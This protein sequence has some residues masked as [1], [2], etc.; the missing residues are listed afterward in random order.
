MC[1]WHLMSEEQL[2][3]SLEVAN[4]SPVVFLYLTPRL[5]VSTG[6]FHNF[7][8]CSAPSAPV[9]RLRCDH[10][11]H[12]SSIGSFWRQSFGRR[13]FWQRELVRQ[14][15]CVWKK[16]SE[17]ASGGRGGG[18]WRYGRG[19]RSAAATREGESSSCAVVAWPEPWGAAPDRGVECLD[20]HHLTR[21][22]GVH[23]W[24][25]F[26]DRRYGF[27]QEHGSSSFCLA[28]PPP[29]VYTL[30]GVALI[31][32]LSL[33]LFLLLL[34]CCLTSLFP[35]NFLAGNPLEKLSSTE[36]LG[37]AD[38]RYSRLPRG[39]SAIGSERFNLA[40]M[41]FNPRFQRN[42]LRVPL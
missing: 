24:R 14:D 41:S 40:K 23:R 28:S 15:R 25:Q 18:G 1:E 10:H 19:V 36:S 22:S 12:Y 34:F 21:A 20:F 39:S 42:I 8:A 26:F 37:L 30:V 9:V 6:A 35:V 38:L 27:H 13:H 16:G 3:W 7:R 33:I 5:S 17:W 31:L 4:S 32:P 29:C 11:S 2:E